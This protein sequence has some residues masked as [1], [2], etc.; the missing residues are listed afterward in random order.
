MNNIELTFEASISG[1]KLEAEGFEIVT[2]I[3]YNKPE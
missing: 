2:S 1:T 3:C